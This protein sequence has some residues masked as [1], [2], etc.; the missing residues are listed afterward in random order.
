L[1]LNDQLPAASPETAV[2]RGYTPLKFLGV[3][4]WELVGALLTG[5]A[6]IVEPGD[7]V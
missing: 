7:E 3:A 4:V 2:I 1:L 6:L 5:L